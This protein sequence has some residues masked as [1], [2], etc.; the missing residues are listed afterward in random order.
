MC[1]RKYIQLLNG[2]IQ[3]LVIDSYQVELIITVNLLRSDLFATVSI[4]DLAI[5]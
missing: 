5:R 1:V 2:S 4:P 3:K